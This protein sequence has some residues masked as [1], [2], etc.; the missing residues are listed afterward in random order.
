[1]MEIRKKRVEI[2]NECRY[3]IKYFIRNTVK[4]KWLK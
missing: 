3:K 4:M 1:M 2:E